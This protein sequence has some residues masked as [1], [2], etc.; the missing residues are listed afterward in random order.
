M[1]LAVSLLVVAAGLGAWPERLHLNEWAGQP[2]PAPYADTRRP[3]RSAALAC[4]AG[5]T[6]MPSGLLLI[7]EK[8]VWVTVIAVVLVLLPGLVQL[9]FHNVRATWRP[10]MP[11]SE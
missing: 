5:A 10:A 1:L 4:C 3:M 8:P 9:G 2:A 11:A 6:L 7:A